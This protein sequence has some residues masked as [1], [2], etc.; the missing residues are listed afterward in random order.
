M[1]NTTLYGEGTIITVEE[2]WL[3]ENNYLVLDCVASKWERQD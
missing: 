2:V 1:F 3:I